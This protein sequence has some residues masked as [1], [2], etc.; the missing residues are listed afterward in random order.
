MEQSTGIVDIIKSR[1]EGI[2]YDVVDQIHLT[3]QRVHWYG[4]VTQVSV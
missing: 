1:L 2:G 3:E 4:F